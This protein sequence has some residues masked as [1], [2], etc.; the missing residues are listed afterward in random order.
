MT[1]ESMALATQ[2][3]EVA[4]LAASATIA[5]TTLGGGEGGGK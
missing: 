2:A 4:L 5:R 3:S 1:L